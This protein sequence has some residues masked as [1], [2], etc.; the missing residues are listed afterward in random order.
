[1]NN[2]IIRVKTLDHLFNYSPLKY[3]LTESREKKFRVFTFSEKFSFQ[4]SPSEKSPKR[5]IR[6]N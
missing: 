4:D 2:K 1:M 3:N 6:I 5:K